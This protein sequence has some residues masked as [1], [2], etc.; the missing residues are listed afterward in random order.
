MSFLIA[1]GSVL[2][3][4]LVV[5]LGFILTKWGWFTEDSQKLLPRLVTNVSLPPFLA[6]TIITH[7]PQN[8]FF[9]LIKGALLPAL[10]MVLLFA[11]AWIFGL[12]AHVQKKHFGLFCACVSN[13]NT[14]FIGIPINQALYGPNAL[15]Y[16]LLYYFASTVFFWTVG[17]FFISRDSRGKNSGIHWQNLISPPIIG[18]ICGI[19]ILL[20][21]IPVPEFIFRAAV[22]T[23][24]MTTPLAL[25]FIGITLANTGRIKISRD[26]IFATCGRL[27]AS[28]LLLWLLLPF[29]HLPPLMGEVFIIQ[30]GLPV[31]TQIAIL[32]AYYGGDSEFGSEMVAFTSIGCAL[33][34]PVLKSLL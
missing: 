5:A 32:S 9:Q 20:A 8:E 26:L 21:K 2:S 14:I 34:V 23:G 17:N 29:F 10:V 12:F 4:L 15:P 25:V 31:L 30:S 33:T 13:P 1:F 28:P 7:F 18:F 22:M 24:E 16:V 19:T 3:L 11:G 27:I 6:T